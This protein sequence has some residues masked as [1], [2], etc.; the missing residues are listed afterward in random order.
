MAETL[1]NSLKALGSHESTVGGDIEYSVQQLVKLLQMDKEF[2]RVRLA[3]IEWG[4]LPLLDPEFSRVG[5]DTLVGVINSEPNFFVDL[6]KIVYRAEN[7]TP[8]DDEMTPQ[9]QSMAQQ[10]RRLLDKLS[11]LPGTRD[12]GTLDFSYLRDWVMQVQAKA[13]AFG[14]RKICDLTLGQFVARASRT[15]GEGWPPPE[16]VTL[17]EEI[18]SEEFFDGF[19]NGMLNSQGVVCRDPMAGGNLERQ[20]IEHYR[21]LA[22]DVRPLGPRLAEALLELARHYEWHAK[23]EDDEAERRRTG[24]F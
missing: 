3:R 21:Q 17:M 2:E 10:A 14:R 8:D 13:E 20:L 15:A 19:V 12:D 23:S 16:L 9:D 6:L 1:E 4:F 11:R 24:R 5:P 18:G 7:D 22:E